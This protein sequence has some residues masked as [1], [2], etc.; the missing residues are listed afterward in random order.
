MATKEEKE[1]EQAYK[2][3][4]SVVEEYANLVRKMMEAFDNGTGSEEL[5][6]ECGRQMDELEKKWI[7]AENVY[8]S[9]VMP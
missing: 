8:F 3:L 1:Q 9:L 5:Y 7:E 6:C 2:E 4:F